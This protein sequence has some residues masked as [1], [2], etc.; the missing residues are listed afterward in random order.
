LLLDEPWEGLDPR[1]LKLVTD[2]LNELILE[3][4]MQLICATHLDEPG[5]NFTHRLTLLDG[6]ISC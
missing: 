5:V 1:N 4:N 2:I 3:N 6:K